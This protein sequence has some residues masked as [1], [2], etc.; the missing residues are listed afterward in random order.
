MLSVY[1]VFLAAATPIVKVV[2][3]AVTGAFCATH[4]AG[5]ITQQRDT[6]RVGE[7]R[8]GEAFARVSV[9]LCVYVC[10]RA[11]AHVHIC[12]SPTLT[13]S[14]SHICVCVY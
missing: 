12:M 3:I 9:S 13:H 6:V 10:L 5:I 2:L 8:D 14:L 4:R 7:G 11:H 1:E